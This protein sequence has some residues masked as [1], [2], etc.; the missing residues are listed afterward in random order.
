MPVWPHGQAGFRIL[1]ALAVWTACED[2]DTMYER[3][4]YPELE[5]IE[6]PQP[7]MPWEPSKRY[8]QIMDYPDGAFWRTYAENKDE[9]S[10][11]FE[12][13]EY[14]EW[15]EQQYMMPGDVSGVISAVLIKGHRDNNFWR[16]PEPESAVMQRIERDVLG[17]EPTQSSDGLRWY[18]SS[19][20]FAGGRYPAAVVANLMNMEA[21]AFRD[22]VRD[23]MAP[24]GWVTI[25]SGNYL[26]PVTVNEHVEDNFVTISGAQE[27][28]PE[29]V[30]L[31]DSVLYAYEKGLNNAQ[32]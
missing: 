32:S 1:L 15:L 12:L 8:E 10:E 14:F 17:L 2:N 9:L 7:P 24:S 26:I 4:N 6:L 21:Q 16:V 18:A 20:G 3:P 28:T 25:R 30:K 13:L 23:N 19:A 11:R 29:G 27:L 31:V 22:H 5:Q